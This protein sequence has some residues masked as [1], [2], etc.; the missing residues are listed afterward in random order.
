[1]DPRFLD[2][3]VS[4]VFPGAANEGDG[5]PTEEEEQE[6]QPPEEEPRVS[7]GREVRDNVVLPQG[8]SRDA[9]YR[10][11]LERAEIGV[12]TSMKYLGLT[13][14]SHW[15]FSA[16]FERLAP[17]VEATANASGRLLPR[18]DGPEFGVRRLYAG[19]V[20]SKLLYGAPIWAEDLMTNRRKLLVIRRLHRTV[21]IRVVRGFRTI[22]AAAAAVLAGFPPFKLQ[23]L[24]CREIYL[25]TRGVSGGVGPEGADFRVRAQ[26]ALLDRW[27]ASLDT[28]A[29]APGIRILG[30]VLPNWDVWL[31]GGGPPLTYRVTQ[32]LTGY[33][34]SIL[35]L[36][37]SQCYN[38]IE[39]IRSTFIYC[40]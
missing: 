26:R 37:H 7:A 9:S 13:L 28:R 31:N 16:G 19:V 24:R 39:S 1:M 35:T 23:A 14:D 4:T 27:R 38:T 33:G 3:V 6:P 34:A 40:L 36:I 15:T 20:R 32:V 10:L 2:K 21:V 29:G 17:S 5:S 8:R 22:S 12:G 11:R 18:L 25:H 30:A